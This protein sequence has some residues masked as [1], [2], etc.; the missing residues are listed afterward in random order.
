MFPE[1]WAKLNQ[2]IRA[3][4]AMLLNG[5][6]SARDRGEEQVPFVVEGARDL[7]E[8]EES[9]DVGV[10]IRWAAP[11]SP[12]TDAVRDAVR[13]CEAHPGPAP[14]YID[15]SDGNGVAVRLGPGA[16]G[17]SPRRTPS[18]HCATSLAATPSP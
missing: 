17:W 3:D 4:A 12:P 9:G 7:S 18:A 16:S 14:L 15:W 11:G 1:A 5:G 2:V 10:A 8:L 13:I 6:Y